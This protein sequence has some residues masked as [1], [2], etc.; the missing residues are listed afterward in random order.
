MNQKMFQKPTREEQQSLLGGGRAKI[1]IWIILVSVVGAGALY[2]WNQKSF[3]EE[4][5]KSAQGEFDSGNYVA[6]LVLYDK[7]QENSPADALIEAKLKEIQELLV[8]EDNFL[9]AEQAAENEQWYDVRA[10]LQTNGATSNAKFKYSA[11]ALEL[12]QQAEGEIESLEKET[13]IQIAN[14]QQTVTEEKSTRARVEQKKSQTEVKLLETIAQ[15]Q[16]TEDALQSTKELLE[17][18][19]KKIAK[20]QSQLEREQRIARAASQEAERERFEKFLNEVKIYEEM[21]RK[22]DEY[23]DFS[24]GEIDRAKDIPA[25]IYIAQGKVL[26]D[27]V[28]IRV[29]EL[30][31]NRTPLA[32]KERT[33]DIVQA[34]TLFI[35]SSRSLRNAVIYI[36]EKQGEEFSD[37]FK[38]GKNLKDRAEVLL[39]RT[40]QFINAY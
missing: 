34:A 8:A 39:Q 1:A 26:F 25:L 2:S 32:Y 12:Y 22:G 38:Q 15:K 11:E 27:E 10:L 23:L 24:L 3:P 35:D 36:E 19:E 33:D 7:L 16:R 37:H 17:E 14:L 21:L 20:T 4:L 6:A 31:S 30:R 40:K 5:E 9:K 18:S 28:Y 29:L 13:A